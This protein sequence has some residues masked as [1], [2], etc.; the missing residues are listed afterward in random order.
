[1]TKDQYRRTIAAARDIVRIVETGAALLDPLT[2]QWAKDMLKLQPRKAFPTPVRDQMLALWEDDLLAGFTPVYIA[3]KTDRSVKKVRELCVHL[4]KE[5]I[6][7]QLGGGV[8][9]RFTRGRAR[10]FVSAMARELARPAFEAE[11]APIQKPVK[12]KKLPKPSKADRP[13]KIPRLANERK[14]RINLARRDD[15]PFNPTD[16]LKRAPRHKTVPSG[17]AIIPAHVKTTV[18]PGYKDRRYEVTLPVDGFV[19]D[20]KKLRGELAR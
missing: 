14:P 12:A 7:F 19:S 5:E 2:V 10:Y 3:E 6:L 13:L 1:M 15:T 4:T 8:G 16:E 20:W 11:V 18:C 17:E 9:N